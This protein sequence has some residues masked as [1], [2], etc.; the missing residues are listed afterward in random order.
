MERLC[1]RIANNILMKI[2]I[3]K[4]FCIL[5][6]PPEDVFKSQKMSVKAWKFLFLRIFGVEMLDQ[7]TNKK[8]FWQY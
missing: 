4:E 7:C 1:N 6:I 3:K 2:I 8:L 5:F